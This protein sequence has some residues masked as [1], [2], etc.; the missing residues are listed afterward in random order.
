LRKPVK[1]LDVG[2]TVDEVKTLT[3]PQRP[4]L[5]VRESS[6]ERKEIVRQVNGDKDDSGE[7]LYVDRSRDAE[8]EHSKEKLEFMACI[9][10]I[11]PRKLSEIRDKRAQRKRRARTVSSTLASAT[12]RV[13]YYTVLYLAVK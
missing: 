9:G 13:H 11:T 10:L 2:R 12:L 8:E 7:E 1:P 6:V 5:F 3:S 4:R